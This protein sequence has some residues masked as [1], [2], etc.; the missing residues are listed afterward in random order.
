MRNGTRQVASSQEICAAEKSKQRCF[1]QNAI[2]INGMD[3]AATAFVDDQRRHR[4]TEHECHH[5]PTVEQGR[6]P[7]ANSEMIRKR[8]DVARHVGG[9]EAHCIES[10]GVQRAGDRGKRSRKAAIDLF[11]YDENPVLRACGVSYWRDGIGTA[12]RMGSLFRRVFV[13]LRG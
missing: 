1:G 6:E 5:D 7:L 13:A 8:G 4:C 3:V 12:A 10:R 11:R 2:G 9:E